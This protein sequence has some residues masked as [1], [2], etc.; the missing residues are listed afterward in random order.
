MRWV[1]CG[2]LVINAVFF[3]WQQFTGRDGRVDGAEMAARSSG[4][5]PIR[6]LSELG[7]DA[8]IE[9]AQRTGTDKC[10]VYGPFFS[11]VESKSFLRSAKRAGIKGLQKGELI[12]LKPY[13]SL[14]VEPLASVKMAQS[15]VNRLRG[16]QLNAELITEG[17][18]RNG[19]SLGN[20]ESKGEVSQ[21][22][23]KLSVHE[24]NVKI[25]GKSRDYRQFWVYL[26][27]GSEALLAGKLQDD[28]I[29]RFPD[30][31]HQQKNCKPVAS[32]E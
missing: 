2:L 5:E 18:L 19:V 27:P 21:L 9:L 30:I 17:R 28:L 11:S 3:G 8:E 16:Y 15:L 10:D 12:Q 14:Y 13:Y 31:F 6:L 32:G 7:E 26:N 23:R 25:V 24:I 4:V 29:V 20:F 22:Q 1:F